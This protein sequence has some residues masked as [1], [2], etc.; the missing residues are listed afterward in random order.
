MSV[1]IGDGAP[2]RTDSSLRGISADALVARLQQDKKTVKGRVHFVLPEKIGRVRVV[3]G[4]DEELVL[5][6]VQ[7]A[8]K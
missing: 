3:S 5:S 2:L 8:L 6:A 4:V 7:S 1:G